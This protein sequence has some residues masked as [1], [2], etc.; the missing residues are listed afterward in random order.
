MKWTAALLT[1]ASFA[2]F[3]FTRAE[4]GL[5][6]ILLKGM[7][8]QCFVEELPEKTVIMVKHEA[9]L[10]DI[11]TKQPLTGIPFQIMVTVR[12]PNGHNIIRQQH[13]PDHKL[14]MTSTLAGE[15]T[16][17]FQNMPTQYVPNAASKF[18]M[19]IFIGDDHDPRITAPIEVKLHELSGVIAENNRLI[20]DIDV[21]QQ[22]QRVSP[23]FQ[24]PFS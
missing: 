7:Q 11:N 16:I 20:A 2:L 18:A 1:V 3:G 6:T 10:I 22:L 23:G 4:M 17:C 5:M 9:T 15:Y 12:D 19:E 13:K 24:R 14:F 8:D 21:E